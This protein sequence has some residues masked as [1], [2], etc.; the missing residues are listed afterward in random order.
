MQREAIIQKSPLQ[1]K[2]RLGLS[3]ATLASEKCPL[4]FWSH[5]KV[6][7]GAGGVK[8]SIA[9]CDVEGVPRWGGWGGSWCVCE[10]CLGGHPLLPVMLRQH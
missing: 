6:E 8:A 4:G 3:S 10:G 2:S 1:R 9:L 5:M 7:A